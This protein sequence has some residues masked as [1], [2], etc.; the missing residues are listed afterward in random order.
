MEKKKDSFE[1]SVQQTELVVKLSYFLIVLMILTIIIQA[2]K[3]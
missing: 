1:K 2:I 3:R